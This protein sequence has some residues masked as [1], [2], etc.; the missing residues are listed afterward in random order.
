MISIGKHSRRTEQ[1]LLYL[2]GSKKSKL[3]FQC[4]ALLF[5]SCMHR[6]QTNGYRMNI[7][8]KE[9][10]TNIFVK[11]LYTKLFN[12]HLNDALIYSP[13]YGQSALPNTL[14]QTS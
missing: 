12:K 6:N 4:V 5:D 9:I 1:L 3:C 2:L 11:N 7:K 13:S 10:A 8:S 14:C